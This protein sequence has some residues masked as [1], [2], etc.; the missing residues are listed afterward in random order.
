MT[1]IAVNPADGSELARYEELDAAGI[2]ERLARAEKAFAA[3]RER[4]VAE[5]AALLGDLAGALRDRASD[6][7]RQASLEMGKPL[8]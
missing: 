7:A 2:E 1:M 4:P 5:R 3:W 8:R 6:L